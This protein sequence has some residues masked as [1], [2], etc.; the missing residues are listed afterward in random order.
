MRSHG[1]GQAYDLPHRRPVT[2]APLHLPQR[3]TA[4][5][6]TLN[7]EG[8]LLAVRHER[9]GVIRWELPGGHAEVGESFRAAAARETEE[10]TGIKV[11]VNHLVAECR[12]DWRG[13]RRSILY[14]G[15]S[16]VNE[17]CTPVARESEIHEAAWVDMGALDPAL[18]SPLIMPLLANSTSCTDDAFV[19]PVRFTATHGQ[20]ANGWEPVITSQWQDLR[21]CR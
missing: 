17:G 16:P 19:R 14:F 8:R 1:S 7:S 3:V 13:S 11:R 15:A 4:F 6:F 18:T 20:S 9:L 21:P 5:A 10:E 2:T 12:H